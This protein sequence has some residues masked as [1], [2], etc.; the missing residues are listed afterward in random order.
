MVWGWYMEMLE[1]LKESIEKI[2]RERIDK[3]SRLGEKDIQPAGFFYS[4]DDFQIS[5]I[6]EFEFQDNYKDFIVHY[7]KSY[8][9]EYL[10]DIVLE[11]DSKLYPIELKYVYKEND[12]PYGTDDPKKFKDDIVKMLKICKEKENIKYAYCIALSGQDNFIQ[13]ILID[14]HNYKFVYQ[15]IKNTR[16]HYLIVEV[17]RKGK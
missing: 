13:D 14:V 1:M 2:V 10:I 3:H 15:P 5:L 17:S 11:K 6:H 7:E 4:E 16:F 12:V 8:G 9:R